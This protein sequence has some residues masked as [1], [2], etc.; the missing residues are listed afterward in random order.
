MSASWKYFLF[1][2]VGL[3]LVFLGFTLIYGSPEAT[4]ADAPTY[5]I[6][7]HADVA[8]APSL[9]HKAGLTLV[10]LGLGTKLGLAPMYSW[11]P[12]TYDAAPPAT[13]AMLAAIQFNVALVFLLRFL[14]VFRASDP[15]LIKNLLL[16]LGLVTMAVSSLNVIAARRYKR[17]IAY[18]SLNHGG[19]IAVGL[20][21]GT[22]AAYGVILYVVSNALIKAILFLT[23]GNIRSQ[24][25]TDDIREVSGLIKDMPYTGILF[26][27][28]IFALLGLPPFGSFLGELLIMSGLIGGGYT[29]IFAAFGLILTV[30]FVATGRAVFPMIWGESRQTNSVPQRLTPVIPKLVFLA[31]L[32]A[33]GLYL[34]P[35]LNGLF[36][37][38]ASRMGAP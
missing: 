24:Y 34:P 16:G 31:A 33:M 22:E 23:A 6:Y 9:W 29:S 28:G 21:L 25:K 11:L 20:G 36:R 14:Q 12:E 8:F 38:V 17:L 37:T 1:S 10:L 13:A 3:G 7:P 15:T 5:F 4:G 26:M 18:A 35:S 27:V 2:S 19:V 32:I 30:T